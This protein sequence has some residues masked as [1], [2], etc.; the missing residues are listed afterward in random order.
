M[1]VLW[2]QIHIQALE[3]HVCVLVGWVPDWHDHQV[4]IVT[5]NG[6]P[7]TTWSPWQQGESYNTITL[8]DYSIRSI[9]LY[10]K[11]KTPK[12]HSNNLASCLD[13]APQ[14]LY[15]LY[16]SYKNIYAINKTLYMAF[17][18]LEK[19][20]GRVTRRVIKSLWAL[21]K[22]GVEELVVRLT[23]SIMKMPEAEC[24]LFTTWV[25]SSA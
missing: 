24:V 1:F 2:N 16:A 23:Q 11:F 5:C 9:D 15:S 3:L 17:V 10:I 21:P 20:L 19:A 6:T 22:L 7:V 18:D 14:T 25:K 13:A 8:Q 12:W 4:A